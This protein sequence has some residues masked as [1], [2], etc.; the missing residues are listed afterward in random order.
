DLQ[1]SPVL[2]G[3]DVIE[4]RADSVTLRL[5]LAVDRTRFEALV[6]GGRLLEVTSGAGDPPAYRLVH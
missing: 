1:G 4:A 3:Y 5:S 6:G 2:K